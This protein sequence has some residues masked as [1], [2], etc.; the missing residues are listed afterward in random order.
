MAFSFES[1]PSHLST[2]SHRSLVLPDNSGGTM[3]QRF[4][5]RLHQLLAEAEI[6]N[7]DDIISW[8]PCGTLF[9][10]HDK[11]RFVKVIMP[12]YFRHSRYK[13]FL[14]QLSMYNFERARSSSKLERGAY[15]HK[16]FQRDHVEQ[17]EHIL[18]EKKTDADTDA[19]QDSFNNTERVDGLFPLP[20]KQFST[21]S[22]TVSNENFRSKQLSHLPTLV[23]AIK[24]ENYLK[25]FLMT[26][27]VSSDILNEIIRTFGQSMET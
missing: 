3:Q 18:R 27:R 19:L 26:S 11:E 12:K 17:C 5:Y 16:F 14:R 20:L 13:S 25:P 15:R 2:P 9:K 1:C 4:P 21:F 8:L 23:N 24:T 10:V 22:G 7:M 6:N